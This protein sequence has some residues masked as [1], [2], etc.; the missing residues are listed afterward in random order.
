M[1]KQ[2]GRDAEAFVVGSDGKI[3]HIVTKYVDETCEG[4][5]PKHSAGLGFSGYRTKSEFLDLLYRE[6]D[7]TL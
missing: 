1:L 6:P 2:N 3:Q 4:L 7:R 5:G